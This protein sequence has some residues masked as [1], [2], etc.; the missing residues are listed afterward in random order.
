M[1][2][3]LPK[4]LLCALCA[5]ISSQ[6]LFAVWDDANPNY[7]Y[8]DCGGVYTAD[9]LTPVNKD[10]YDISAPDACVEIAYD[11]PGDDVPFYI[12][13]MEGSVILNGGGSSF[14][15]G[16][17]YW[18]LDQVYSTTYNAC[19][20]FMGGGGYPQWHI[21]GS[22]TIK[23]D[24]AVLFWN[25]SNAVYDETTG[26]DTW[27]SDYLMPD[28]SNYIIRC[29]SVDEKTLSRL[30]PYLIRDDYEDN[31]DTGEYSGGVWGKSLDDYSF[32]ATTGEDG[33]AYIYLGSG[34]T[35]G[36][37]GSSSEEVAPLPP[38]TITVAAGETIVLGKDDGLMPGIDRPVY[39]K[40]GIADASLLDDSLLNNQII[41]GTGGSLLTSA[42]QTM[43]LKGSGSVS[44]SIIAVGD[45]ASAAALEIGQSGTM[46][47]LELKGERYDSAAIRVK[48]GVLT[49]SGKTT[50]G[51]GSG[52]SSIEVA[53]NASVT[54]Y[55]KIAGDITTGDSSKVLNQGTISG[56]I[57]VAKNAI[58]TNN[59]TISGTLTSSGMVYGSGVFGDTQLLSG[60][61]LHVGNSPGYQKHSSLT[62]ERGS[63]LSFTVDG[64][65]SATLSN[66]GS[67]THSVLTTDELTITPGTGS[68]TINVEVTMGIVD[69][70]YEPVEVTLASAGEGNATAADFTINL[71]DNNLLEEGSAVTWDAA[72]QSLILSGSVNKAALAVL[73]DSNS[74]NVANT[75]WASANAVQEMARTAEHQF[76]VGMPGQTTFWGAAMG[77]FMDISGKQGFTSNLGGYAVGLQHAFT[78]K[79]R[80][81]FALGQSFGTFKSDDNQ[82][83]A[84]QTALMPVLTAQYVSPLDKTSSLTVSGH[85]AYGTVSNEADTYQA[86]TIGKAEWDDQV[87]NIGVRAAW[88]KKVTDD[89][90]ISVFAGLTYQNVEQDSF[91]EEYTGGERDYRSGSMSS[92]SLPLGVT[93][94][95]VYQM[96]G[97]NIF[98]PEVTVA[99]IGDIVRENPEVKTSVYGFNRVGKGSN[100]GR[101]A[102]MLNA[103]ANWMFD[104]SWSLGAFYT[105]EARSN[106]V[107]QSV[108]AALRYSF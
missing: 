73:M 107:N 14:G 87:L 72:T 12:A 15:R 108:N 21:S 48:G 45:S 28:S 104:S 64:V 24:T 13:N 65:Q 23:S 78:E 44:Y 83:K 11:A 18:T 56:N 89:S 35:G 106:Q 93:W 96:E 33:Y 6:P 37:G 31:Y 99:Y 88:N 92:L 20:M 57:D 4:S 55:G 91:T 41:Q 86:G 102:F 94:R 80:A 2:L 58:L 82:L 7:Y 39:I 98:V 10:V 19:V 30:K 25:E 27:Q 1:K 36:N 29:G 76:L 74:A 62:L 16:E 90:S 9:G 59:G 66:A 61:V 81:G 26:W 101:N 51:I 42:G 49:I 105:L 95:G 69:A 68:V 8:C 43:I 53:P 5:V 3:H 70:G 103:G 67:G 63:A 52:I 22:L 100:I 77:S 38:T 40:G 34:G 60:A 54:N 50:L 97:T 46:S 32:Y 75:M 85:V 47:N 84:D 71:N 79:F 17:F